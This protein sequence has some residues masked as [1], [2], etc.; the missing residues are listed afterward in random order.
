MS[1]SQFPRNQCLGDRCFRGNH[2]PQ[3][4]AA[5]DVMRRIGA[6]MRWIA[7]ILA[8]ISTASVAQE[9][10]V[11]WRIDPG[12]RVGP[13][14]PST[15]EVDLRALFG[16]A[17]ISNA[18]VDLGEGFVTP[19]TVVYQNDPE[20]RIE[21]IWRDSQRISPKEVR[22][23]GK[24]SKWAT[25]DGVSLG[26]TLKEVEILNGYPFRLAGFDFDYGGTVVDCGKGRLTYLG[27]RTFSRKWTVRFASDQRP[28]S[29]EYRQV[30]G[31][32]VFSS[33]HP[34]MQAVNPT[35]YQLIVAIDRE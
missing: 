35:V 21:I 2:R 7:T 33:G 29:P 1:S 9:A 22:L 12:Q 26:T 14:N 13:I 19:G 20:R 5:T 24:A 15:S 16:D 4:R 31:D 34:A 30:I 23:T 32:H 10:P 25:D 3:A 17:A 8:M 11:D 28:P 6:P 18:D 27:C